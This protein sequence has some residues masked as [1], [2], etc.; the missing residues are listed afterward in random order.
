MKVIGQM[1]LRFGL[2]VKKQLLITITQV[3]MHFTVCFK[4]RDF[5]KSQIKGG[6]I[7]NTFNNVEQSFINLF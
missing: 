5:I 3:V 4:L 1:K 6:S 7:F 2:L